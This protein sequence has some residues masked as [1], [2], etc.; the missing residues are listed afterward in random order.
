MLTW[1]DALAGERNRQLRGKN[2]RHEI[3]NLV[4]RRVAVH[5][6]LRSHECTRARTANTRLRSYSYRISAHRRPRQRGLR[7]LPHWWPLQGHTAQLCC[8]SQR[9]ASNRPIAHTS[10]DHQSLRSMSLRARLGS[11]PLRP[12]ASAGPLHRLPQRFTRPRQTARP[13]GD[14]SAVRNLSQK[15]CRL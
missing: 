9:I 7:F 3:K 4:S 1:R 11:N 5:G 12:Q 14:D 15:Y 13:R 6:I 8:L 10:A 2:A